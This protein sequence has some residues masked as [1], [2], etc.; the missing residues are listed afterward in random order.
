MDWFINLAGS[1]KEKGTTMMIIMAKLWHIWIGN[2][3]LNLD[4][5]QL[6]RW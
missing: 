2:E 3:L 1:D 6:I 5:Y 4:A